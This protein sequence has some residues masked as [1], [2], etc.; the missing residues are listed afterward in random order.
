MEKD[1]NLDDFSQEDMVN[2]SSEKLMHRAE[3]MI[4]RLES[5]ARQTE[6]LCS[7]NKDLIKTLGL[8]IV[9]GVDSAVV[10]GKPI[11]LITGVLNGLRKV[12]K[13]QFNLI[14]GDIE[15]EADA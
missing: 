2:D 6:A 11:M 14:M 4:S 12:L 9:F 3:E 5:L 8:G 1:F 13:G 10:N 7:A 15:N